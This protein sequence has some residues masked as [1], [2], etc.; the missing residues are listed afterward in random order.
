MGQSSLNLSQA[1]ISDY[2]YDFDSNIDVTFINY[3]QDGLVNTILYPNLITVSDTINF[4]TFP[5]F[6][7]KVDAATSD[8]QAN[9][10]VLPFD[11]TQAG[12][13]SGINDLCPDIDGDGVLSDTWQFADIPQDDTLKI[14]SHQFTSIDNLTWSQ[15]DG[16]YKTNLKT[17]FA[18]LEDPD[19][20]ES[21]ITY[22]QWQYG[23]ENVAIDAN[24][25]YDSLV[26]IAKIDT[27]I[28]DADGVFYIDEAEFVKLI[29]FIRKIK[30]LFQHLLNLKI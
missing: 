24:Y 5:G 15:E 25:V 29:V 10:E 27:N 9:V 12:A 13:C 6:L 1:P 2:F 18:H 14:Y 4:K 19:D 17:D 16:R 7:L 20:P 30:S 26:Y 8:V 3:R 23:V 28:T 22:S 11:E 21:D